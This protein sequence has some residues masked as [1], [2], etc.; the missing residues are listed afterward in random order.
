MT[1]SDYIKE[2]GDQRCAELFKVKERTVA[3]WRRGENFPRAVKAREIVAVTG[4]SVTM[5]GIYHD[6]AVNA[7]NSPKTEVA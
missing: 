1:L 7:E 6:P 5:A 2:H 3:S 4:G